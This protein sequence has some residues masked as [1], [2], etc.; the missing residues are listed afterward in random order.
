MAIYR[1]FE[2]IFASAYSNDGHITYDQRCDNADVINPNLAQPVF[3]A[4]SDAC[5]ASTCRATPHITT[6]PKEAR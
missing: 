5:P 6:L 3:N 2:A 4:F 1:F